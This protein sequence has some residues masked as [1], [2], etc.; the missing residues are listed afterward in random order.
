MGGSNFVSNKFFPDWEGSNQ[1][2]LQD[3]TNT[4]APDYMHV[5]EQWFADTLDECCE[6]HYFWNLNACLGGSAT[7]TDKWYVDWATF[8]CV[9]DC[10]EGGTD[11]GGFADSYGKSNLHA[12]KNQCCDTHV[13]WDY[14]NCM[15]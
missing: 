12:S 15:N 9:K 1:S 5:T 10:A 7:G 4:P 14:T 6:K 2:C 3:A 13:G 8:K 11:C